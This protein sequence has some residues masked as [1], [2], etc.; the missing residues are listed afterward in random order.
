MSEKVYITFTGLWSDPATHSSLKHKLR[1][2]TKTNRSYHHHFGV[3]LCP[4]EQQTSGEEEEEC[5]DLLEILCGKHILSTFVR[6]TTVV[7]ISDGLNSATFPKVFNG[8]K[9]VAA[10]LLSENCSSVLNIA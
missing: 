5:F 3:L 9:Q 2:M 10:V 1:S 6:S 7:D 8:R 4:R